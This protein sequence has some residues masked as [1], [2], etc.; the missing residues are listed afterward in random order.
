MFVQDSIIKSDDYI[1]FKQLY[2]SVVEEIKDVEPGKTVDVESESFNA[3][4]T[5]FVAPG[6]GQDPEHINTVKIKAGSNYTIN[7]FCIFF[8]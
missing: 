1:D 8:C 3:I 7:S 4:G 6:F 2:D 5:S